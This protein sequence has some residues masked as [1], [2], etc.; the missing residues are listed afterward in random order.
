L[1]KKKLLKI[2]NFKLKLKKNIP[3]EAGLG[4]GSMNAANILNFL[5]KK[6]IIKIIK[7]KFEIFLSL[8]G[9]DVILGINFKSAILKSNNNIK[10]FSNC[11]KFSYFLVNQILDVLQKKFIQ[12]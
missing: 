3:Q 6:K 7:K 9:S 5:I 2:K 8:I 10:K 4:G 11:P 1:I 12:E